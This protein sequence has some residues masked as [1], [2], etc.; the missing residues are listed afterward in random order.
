[1]EIKMMMRTPKLVTIHS[2]KSR[3]ELELQ[4]TNSQKESIIDTAMRSSQRTVFFDH[5]E[6]SSMERLINSDSMATQLWNPEDGDDTFSE[7][8]IRT[9]DTQYKVVEGIHN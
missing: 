8:L 6:Y 5:K 2:P 7:T 1:M 9:R 4:G 3:F